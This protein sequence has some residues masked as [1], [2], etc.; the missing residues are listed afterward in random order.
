[1]LLESQKHAA[2]DLD[3][4]VF[5]THQVNAFFTFGHILHVI[6]ICNFE[7]SDWLLVALPKL[8]RQYDRLPPVQHSQKPHKPRAVKWLDCI[9]ANS[10][11]ITILATT[12]NALNDVDCDRHHAAT[13]EA[14]QTIHREAWTPSQ[15]L[16]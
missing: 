10:G 3:S 7:D 13:A 5:C 6:F 15:F 2:F 11:N 8:L 12:S 4:A 14:F 1:M 9:V 16:L